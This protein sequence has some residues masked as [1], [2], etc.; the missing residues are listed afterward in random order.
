[1]SPTTRPP[2]RGI[3]KRD[4]RWISVQ[5]NIRMPF[6]YKDQLESEAETQHVSVN[7]LVLD[8]LER[9]YKPAPPED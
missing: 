8:G 2:I 1:M 5:M 7:Q 3:N 6:W 4:P 9:I